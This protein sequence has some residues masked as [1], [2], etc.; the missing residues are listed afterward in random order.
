MTAF[1]G[2]KAVAADALSEGRKGLILG[3]LVALGVVAA[4]AFMRERSHNSLLDITPGQMPTC[5]SSVARHGLRR[6]IDGSP[7]AEQTGLVVQRIGSVSEGI[8]DTGS[9]PDRRTCLA[10]VFTNAGRDLV[11]FT[12]TWSSAEQADVYLEIPGGLPFVPNR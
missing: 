5:T 12:L 10:E 6:T 11:V 9:N 7:A 3:G 1:K 4:A 2:W 8:P